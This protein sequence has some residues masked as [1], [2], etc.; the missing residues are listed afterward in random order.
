[1][2]MTVLL[3]AIFL[4][5]ILRL[6]Y[7]NLQAS[8]LTPVPRVPSTSAI[9]QSS[10]NGQTFSADLKKSIKSVLILSMWFGTHMIVTGFPYL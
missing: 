10:D 8:H 7:L 4:Q 1:M 3:F 5:T 2:T 6:I 9:G